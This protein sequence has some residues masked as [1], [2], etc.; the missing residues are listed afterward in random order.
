LILF[1][2]FNWKISIYKEIN[3]SAWHG[4]VTKR[5][6]SRDVQ[7]STWGFSPQG[8]DSPQ[9]CIDGLEREILK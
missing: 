2:F 5:E 7:I 4:Y 1:L 6:G 3:S 8:F 9:E